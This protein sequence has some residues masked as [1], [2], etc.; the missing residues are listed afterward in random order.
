VVLREHINIQRHNQQ[1]KT[2]PGPFKFFALQDAEF[3]F[4]V[5]I[6]NFELIQVALL[7]E[8]IKA[9]SEHRI[10]LGSGKSKGYGSVIFTMF[11]AD[12]V[13]F[14]SSAPGKELRGIAEHPACTAAMR[15]RYGLKESTPVALPNVTWKPE[16]PWR[17]STQFE[18]VEFVRV[19]NET[20]SQID[21]IWP[22]V[23]KLSD[24]PREATV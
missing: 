14:G 6:R 20:A 1:V 18:Y 15:E 7:G 16:T 8:A 19:A 4:T 22:N 23:A 9:V 24:R 12:L 11:G 10:L 2:P 13:Q 17:W 5:R 21:Q 3:L